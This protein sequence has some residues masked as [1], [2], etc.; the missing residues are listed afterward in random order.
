MED[1]RNNA[2][3]SGALENRIRVMRIITRMNIG[4]PAIQVTG[5][6]REMDQLKFDQR[7][8]AGRCDSD[9]I[10]YLQASNVGAVVEIPQLRRKLNFINDLYVLFYLIREI[11][12]FKPHVIHTHTSKAGLLGRIAALLSFSPSVRVH[13]F[14]G[15][16]LNG[17]FNPLMRIA[18]IGIER[19]MGYVTD[20]MLAVGEQVRTD[21]L[22]Y[23]V[24]NILKFG[25]MPPGVEVKNLP[26]R[27][28]SQKEF[29]LHDADFRC[30]F[31]GRLTGVKRL[32]R[33][34]D[35]VSEIQK[36]SLKIE[37]IVVGN[38]EMYAS[39]RE[40]VSIEN[41][42]VTFLGWQQNIEKI[43]AFTDLV[44]LTSDN[45]GMPISLIQAGMAGIPVI[46]TNVGS[47]REVV[48]NGVTGIVVEPSVSDLVSAVEEL[49]K[50]R[51]LRHR[52][53]AAAVDF[54]TNRFSIKRLVYDHENLYQQLVGKSN[55]S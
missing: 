15:H 31:I 20:Y 8:Y 53:G 30:A 2:H 1:L 42:P 37:F 41:L 38:G 18:I 44:I 23:R 54:T 17:Y 32:D 6:L 10:E 19:M 46:A 55:L 14:H 5:L 9:E 49:E 22:K 24:G 43:L 3:M 50:N 27:N 21:L 45:E 35:V 25:V 39:A 51:I 48:Q 28:F 7:L 4:G 40:R 36:R 29:G 47:V 13:T 11:R 33:F 34:L 26:D 12:R 16:L 52:F